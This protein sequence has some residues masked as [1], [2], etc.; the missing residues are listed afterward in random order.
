MPMESR[1]TKSTWNNSEPGDSGLTWRSA[2]LG[3]SLVVLISLGGPYSIWMAG[4]SEITWSHF[5]VGVGVPFLIIVFFNALVR[6]LFCN[7]ALHPA[8]LVIILVMGLIA[9]T[10]PIFIVGTF[11]GIISAPYYA[12]TVENEWADYIQ[13]YL[14]EWAIPGAEGEA[15]RWFFEGLPSG[16]GLPLD[17]WIGPLCWWLSL[18]LAIYFL[19]FCLV[20]ILRRQWVDHERLIF[21]LT[22]MP[23]L[24]IADGGTAL[25]HARMFWIGCSVPV[26]IILYNSISYFYP[27]FPQ[28]GIHQAVTFQI[29]R[30]FP[31]V[32]LM[33]YLPVMGFM[34]LASTS[35]SFSIWFFY[36]IA[37]VQEGITNRF[38][39][40]ITR[41]DPFVWGMQS[42]SWQ[43]WGAFTAMVI[44]SFWMARKHLRAV[45]RQVFMGGKE[46]DDREEMV[47]YRTAVYGTLG[48]LTYILA[49]L[50]YSGMDLHVAL[51]FVFGVLVA[52]IGITRL[53]IQS[54]LYYLTPPVGGQAFALA[55]LGTAIAPS[56]LVS[57]SL[58]YAWF[59]D[60][61]SIFMPTAAN[62]AKLNELCRGR[63][64]MVL[65][66]SLAV[67][68]GFVASI[69]FVL[70]LC[71]KYGGGN[72]RSWY[73]IAGGGVGGMAFNGVVQQIKNPWFPDWGKLSFFGIGTL[74]YSVL[75]ACQY[76]FH[77][78]PLHPVGLALASLWMTRLIAVSVF[79]AWAA[80][81]LILHLGG[82]GA[83][84]TARP[85][86][87]GLIAGFFLGVG[88]SYGMD[89]IWFYGKG[90]PIL[91]G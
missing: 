56:N 80:K 1:S 14:P 40:D 6:R 78:W 86:F 65:A 74:L 33:I 71:Y 63:R 58:S 4:S 15:M 89:L 75:A 81:S 22:E 62:G 59:G 17:V 10:I 84:R 2:G 60:V 35:I 61:Q 20:V 38:G 13:P 87:I 76:R 46:L 21:P 27:G 64:S 79:L 51:L 66:M 90:H 52:Y 41:P 42:L 34:F 26:G 12:A 32:F 24:L 72:F 3:L 31:V 88:I 29:S 28:I 48:G 25:L 85:F 23:R 37:V 36:L 49:W 83:Y 30:E 16:Y 39:Y 5:P 45:C 70:Y 7:W 50:C 47:S 73:F 19:C 54:G 82:I 11:L 44:W 69:Y 68:A 55:V 77:W 57:L 43:S 67:V 91:N 9:T 8:E 18:I 53:V